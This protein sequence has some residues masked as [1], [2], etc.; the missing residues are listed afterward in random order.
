VHEFGERLE[1]RPAA[2]ALGRLAPIARSCAKQVED[3]FGLLPPKPLVERA[4]PGSASSTIMVTLS[5]SIGVERPL[6]R[7]APP[8][9]SERSRSLAS[10]SVHCC[11]ARRVSRGGDEA[12]EGVGG[13]SSVIFT[14]GVFSGV[15]RGSLSSN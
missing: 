13:Q 12:I 6:S 3:R 9:R 11:K 2:L 8:A 1:D 14:G 15:F 5:S 7:R 10:I 4:D